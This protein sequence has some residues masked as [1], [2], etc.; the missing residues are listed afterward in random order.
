MRSSIRG[1]TTM[2]VGSV[3]AAA[4]VLLVG[5]VPEGV[6]GAS[7][8]APLAEF[9]VFV[10]FPLTAPTAVWHFGERV[11]RFFSRHASASAP[12]GV[13]EAQFFMKSDWHAL[14]MAVRCAD[15]GWAAVPM[16]GQTAA[17]RDSS[18]EVNKT[19]HF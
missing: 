9:P 5:V 16:V 15:V 3:A 1:E 8:L 18:K 13:T 7:V 19:V 6:F 11:G 10:G 4:G 12:P 2:A 14:R 17:V